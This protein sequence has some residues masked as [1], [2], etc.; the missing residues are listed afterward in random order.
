MTLRCVIPLSQ[1]Q[2][3]KPV[4]VDGHDCHFPAEPDSGPAG[5]SNG[6]FAR[7]LGTGGAGQML[8]VA[9]ALFAAA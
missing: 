6:S 3:Y 9:N 4:S 8:P 2:G 7:T 1:I 5:L